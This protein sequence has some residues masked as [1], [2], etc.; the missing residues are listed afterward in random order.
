MIQWQLPALESRPGDGA[1]ARE[2]N[3]GSEGAESSEPVRHYSP[4]AE[5]HSADRRP[6]EVSVGC[7]MVGISFRCRGSTMVIWT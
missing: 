3:L 6:Q 4:R 1:A 7:S 2:G 5:L